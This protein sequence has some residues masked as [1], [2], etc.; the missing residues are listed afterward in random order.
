M[1]A[2]FKL[3]F[4]VAILGSLIIN[5]IAVADNSW[6]ST[7]GNSVGV[8]EKS[9]YE[10]QA[11]IMASLNEINS[12]IC[13][14]IEDTPSCQGMAPQKSQAADQATKN[15]LTSSAIKSSEVSRTY[16]KEK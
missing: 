14:M 15:S 9:P 16:L 7:T 13:H 4:M 1:R 5:S 12:R 8:S 2:L 10:K 11:Y 6:K 3:G